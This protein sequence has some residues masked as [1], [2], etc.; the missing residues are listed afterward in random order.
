MAKC[1]NNNPF[2][3]A[4][5]L[6]DRPDTPRSAERLVFINGKATTEVG[7]ALLKERE[8]EIAQLEKAKLIIENGSKWWPEGKYSLALKRRI[9]AAEKV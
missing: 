5:P 1:F 3:R 8:K 4:V 7:Q 9:R 2:L 6:F